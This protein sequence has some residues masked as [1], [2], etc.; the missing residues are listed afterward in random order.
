[1]YVSLSHT[2]HS[3]FQCA[4]TGYIGVVKC[5]NLSAESDDYP[6]DSGTVVGTYLEIR[7]SKLA[8]V[9]GTHVQSTHPDDTGIIAIEMIRNHDLT[10][11][12]TIVVEVHLLDI[13]H[14]DERSSDDD[15]VFVCKYLMTD[16]NSHAP[17]SYPFEILHIRGQTPFENSTLYK[18]PT[19]LID[20]I[21]LP[22]VRAHSYKMAMSVWMFAGYGIARDVVCIIV[23]LA[24]GSYREL[25]YAQYCEAS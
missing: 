4:K 10:Y 19:R 18:V 6:S 12:N 1:M 21:K 8:L 23:V 13:D 5:Y 15:D 22:Q 11:I 17:S 24:V 2:A 20:F 25:D 14:L 16:T 7:D 9:S 3:I